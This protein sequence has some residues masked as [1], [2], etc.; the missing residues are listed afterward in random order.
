MRAPPDLSRHALTAC[1]LGTRAMEVTDNVASLL[2]EGVH[3]IE[4]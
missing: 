4:P 3:R 1:F 2:L